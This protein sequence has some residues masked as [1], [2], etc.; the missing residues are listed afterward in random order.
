MTAPSL[1]QSSSA[2][3]AADALFA[4]LAAALDRF[5]GDAGRRFE[6]LLALLLIDALEDPVRALEAV[7][8]AARIVD[9]ESRGEGG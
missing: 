9:V 6:S 4:A 8:E 5:D 1:P 3:E 7:E 2:T